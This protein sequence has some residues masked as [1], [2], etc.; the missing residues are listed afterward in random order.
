L[1]APFFL[2]QVLCLFLWSLDDYW[3]YSLRPLFLLLVFE[4]VL[5]QQRL[6]SLQMLRSMRKDPYFLFVYRMGK[7]D[8]RLSDELV[9]G[10]IVSLTADSLT[11]QKSTPS[12]LHPPPSM[13]SLPSLRIEKQSKIERYVPCDAVII[14]GSCVVNEA[15]LTG[16]PSSPESIS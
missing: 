2:F 5:A 4:G 10:D 12:F 11:V 6:M 16:T 8:L 3:M 9:P 7:W 1:V 15:M 14:R 13:S